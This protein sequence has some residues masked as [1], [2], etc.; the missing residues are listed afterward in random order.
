MVTA[1][2]AHPAFLPGTCVSFNQGR[3]VCSK[4]TTCMLKAHRG[5]KQIQRKA[6]DPR[7]IRVAW[8]PHTVRREKGK[9]WQIEF[10]SSFPHG[11][12]IFASWALLTLKA[13][14]WRTNVAAWMF[15]L[16]MITHGLNAHCREALDDFVASN[17]IK[18]G[19]GYSWCQCSDLL[20]PNYSF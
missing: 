17:Q 19:L 2:M 12:W 7:Y 11:Q 15:Y 6:C 1:R 4:N 18:S 10:S 16:W 8:L 9:S 13:S 20:E 5:D 3:C 14:A